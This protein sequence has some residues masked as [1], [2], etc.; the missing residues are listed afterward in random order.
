MNSKIDLPDEIDSLDGQ[1]HRVPVSLRLLVAGPFEGELA[2]N[3]KGSYN[4]TNGR[5]P[6]SQRKGILSPPVDMLKTKNRFPKS[7]DDFPV[8]SPRQVV[9]GP[10]GRS[11]PAQGPADV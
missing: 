1:T 7:L 2:I 5:C 10:P 4:P 11:R 9:V 8:N 3:L 6:S